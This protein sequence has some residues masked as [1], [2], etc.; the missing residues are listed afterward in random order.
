MP[1]AVEAQVD[2]SVEGIDAGDVASSAAVLE[3]AAEA[4]DWRLEPLVRERSVEGH[5]FGPVHPVQVLGLEGVNGLLGGGLV[6]EL[7]VL[8]GDRRLAGLAR[9]EVLTGDPVV[10]IEPVFLDD[11]E[12]VGRIVV[13]DFEGEGLGHLRRDGNDG[14]RVRALD[15]GHDL[16]GATVVDPLAEGTIEVTLAD[17]HPHRL[18][19]QAGE[20]GLVGEE[21]GDQVLVHAGVDGLFGG[22]GI[23]CRRTLQAAKLRALSLRHSGQSVKTR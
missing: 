20:L 17:R 6:I 2:A 4:H 21:L 5:R 12:L 22:H 9:R 3:L 18:E 8:R 16:D 10:H 19:V 23:A 11:L 14:L 1:R 7:D 15:R 13:V